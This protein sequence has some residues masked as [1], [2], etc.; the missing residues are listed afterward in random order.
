MEKAFTPGISSETIVDDIQKIDPKLIREFI[1]ERR[2]QI[3]H[4]DLQNRAL[5][6]LDELMDLVE[7]SGFLNTIRQE[8]MDQITSAMGQEAGLGNTP[9]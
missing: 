3:T 1:Q 4:P 9:E 7:Q 5:D 2:D 6:M 8:R